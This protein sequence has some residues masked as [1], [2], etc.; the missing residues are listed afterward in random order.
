MAEDNRVADRRSKKIRFS[1]KTPIACDQMQLADKISL[2]HS[3]MTQK[4]DLFYRMLFPP[5]PY[6]PEVGI[7]RAITSSKSTFFEALCIAENLDIL[8]QE[9][10]TNSS[11]NENPSADVGKS[12][13]LLVCA[14]DTSDTVLKILRSTSKYC[15]KCRTSVATQSLGDFS[16]S[17]ILCTFKNLSAKAAT[18]FPLTEGRHILLEKTDR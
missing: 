16:L 10:G 5:R 2:A 11:S 7:R 12:R 15:W 4:G 14:L 18:G 9:T 17:H 13:A 6:K 8:R 1:R 3:M